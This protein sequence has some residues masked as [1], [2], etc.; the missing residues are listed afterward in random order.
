MNMIASKDR[1]KISDSNGNMSGNTTSSESNGHHK[2]E[3]Q[4]KDTSSMLPPPSR[5]SPA[6][7]S[8]LPPKPKPKSTISK[9]NGNAAAAAAAAATTTDDLATASRT[10]TTTSREQA[11]AEANEVLNTAS[12]KRGRFENFNLL[13]VVT[14][15]R[16][17]MEL[18]R[19]GSSSSV[20][21]GG[22]SSSNLTNATA[23]SS[24]SGM[25]QIS[26]NFNTNAPQPAT[27]SS[28]SPSPLPSLFSSNTYTTPTPTTAA[29]PSSFGGLM[30]SYVDPNL[31]SNI[32]NISESITKEI[33][34]LNSTIYSYS[35]NYLGQYPSLSSTVGAM[36]GGGGDFMSTLDFENELIHSMMMEDGGGGSGSN[37]SNGGAYFNGIRTVEELPPQLVNLDLTS[38]E[39]YLRRCGLLAHAFDKQMRQSEGRIGIGESKVIQKGGNKLNGAGTEADVNDDGGA[40]D[41]EVRPE[42]EEEEAD[43]TAMIPEIFF[44]PF[45]DLTDPKT[46]E[47]LLVLNDDDDEGDN[48]DGR[49]DVTVEKKQKKSS[50]KKLKTPVSDN[51]PIIRI[52]KPEKL[53]QYLDTVELSLLNQVRSKS[54]S[55]FQETNR[56]SY[57]KSLVADLVEEVTSLRGQ[58]EQIR[59]RSITEVELIPVMDRRRKDIK[60][61]GQVLD[62]IMDV[63]EVKGSVAGLIASGDF[64]GAVEAIH[65]AK[66]LLNGSRSTKDDSSTPSGRYMLGKVV[67]L[68]KVNDQLDQYENLVVSYIIHSLSFSFVCFR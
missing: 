15:P 41:G 37:S 55:F 19:H 11:I 31:L 29:S 3:Q 6:F 63:V 53:T 32:S 26:N 36:G 4:Q 52:P 21:G 42:E 14:S 2:Q 46:F 68:N 1:R 40:G 24:S 5:I 61:L 51:D 56:F 12:Y 54:D 23:S 39:G 67:A 10:T 18:S 48:G 43:P 20:Q 16:G 47:S 50:S 33:E 22:N 60:V 38:V 7:Q 35:R 34:S 49:S 30:E 44:S 13:G 66:N 59:E 25:N 62:E 27:P 17:M 57:L 28:F 64:L 65:S 9:T 45:F 8:P 58:L